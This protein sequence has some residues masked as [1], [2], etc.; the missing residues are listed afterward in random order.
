MFLLVMV[1]R[2]SRRRAEGTAVSP[3]ALL[4]GDVQVTP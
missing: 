3:A 4:K 2:E 1:L